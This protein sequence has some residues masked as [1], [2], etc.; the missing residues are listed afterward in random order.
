MFR[1]VHQTNSTKT[2]CDPDF[3]RG[4]LASWMGVSH[5]FPTCPPASLQ[6]FQEIIEKTPKTKHEHT[7]SLISITSISLNLSY[8]NNNMHIYI[9][10]HLLGKLPAFILENC[11]LSWPFSACAGC[12][13]AEE[14]PT[15]SS[16]RLTPSCKTE[17]ILAYHAVT[18]TSSILHNT[19]TMYKIIY[20]YI[21]IY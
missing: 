10:I 2:H 14:V 3:Q 15:S 18:V 8:I 1:N 20:I 17:T 9:Y 12:I 19:N 11:R 13:V 4:C 21:Y 6:K 5:G 7:F 16:L